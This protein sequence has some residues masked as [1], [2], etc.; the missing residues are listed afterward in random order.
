MDS[1]NKLGHNGQRER[2]PPSRKQVL[3][4][5]IGVRCDVKEL[6]INRLTGTHSR[7]TYFTFLGPDDK[8][9]RLM[10]K[11]RAAYSSSI[12]LEST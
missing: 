1:E 5:Q 7:W 8:R 11:P 6:N 2:K 12:A 4:G 10:I 9:G 3:Y